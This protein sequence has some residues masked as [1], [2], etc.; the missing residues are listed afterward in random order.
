MGSGSAGVVISDL[1]ADVFDHGKLPFLRGGTL[2]AMSFGHRPIAN[3]GAVPRSIKAHWGSEWKKAALSITIEPAE[4][5][6]LAS[7]L[8]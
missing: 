4:S 3:F 6:L 5:D 1:D 2:S 8:P 7:N